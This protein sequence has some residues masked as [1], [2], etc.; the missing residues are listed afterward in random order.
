MAVVTGITDAARKDGRFVVLVDGRPFATV[1]LDIIARLELHVGDELS[2][3]QTAVLE[4]EAGALKTF[5][6]ALNMLA[7]QARSSRDMRRRLVQKGEEPE[8]VD[9][10]IE[11]MEAS[12]LIDDAQYARQV[13][14]S[15]LLG[16]GA[17]KRRLQQELFKRGVARGTADEAIAE[18]IE[19][20]DVD[21]DAAV[22][23]VAEKK[24]RTLQ[25]EDGPTRRRRLYAFLARRGYDGDVIRRAIADVL[26][27]PGADGDDGDDGEDG[28]DHEAATGALG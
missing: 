22:R 25:K 18:V 7:F 28:T 4:R 8:H 12:G 26:G 11:K 13:A 9:A 23:E 27:G 20:E 5:D 2:E 3:A 24:L 16:A 10:A 15:K 6:R 21:E 14:R 19:E 1:S 17:S